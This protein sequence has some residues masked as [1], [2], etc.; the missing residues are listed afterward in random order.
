M[1]WYFSKLQISYFIKMFTNSIRLHDLGFLLP[2]IKF[3]LSPQSITCKH[4]RSKACFI[5][6]LERCEE[7]SCVWSIVATF[8]DCFA[9]RALQPIKQIA[10]SGCPHEMTR[11]VSVSP[12]TSTTSYYVIG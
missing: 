1:I 9:R 11:Q 12:Y 7:H 5:G 10:F 2:I 8:V 6:F 4:S 3:F